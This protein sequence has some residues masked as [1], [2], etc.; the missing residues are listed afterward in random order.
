MFLGTHKPFWA[1]IKTST[2]CFEKKSNQ[3]VFSSVTLFFTLNHSLCFTMCPTNSS[4]TATA[5]TFALLTNLSPAYADIP[6]LSYLLNVEGDIIWHLPEPTYSL[7]Y[8][9]PFCNAT[10]WREDPHATIHISAIDDEYNNCKDCFITFDVCDSFS[11]SHTYKI[12]GFWVNKSSE[13]KG[14]MVIPQH[15]LHENKLENLYYGQTWGF[16][17]K[18]TWY[19]DN[20]SLLSLPTSSIIDTFTSFLSLSNFISSDL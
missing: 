4:V 13:R 10:K 18:A 11:K 6:K 1:N 5:T 17:D 2:I 7:F 15:T 8:Q 9:N 3:Q 19:S 20:D 16:V 14:K 12:T